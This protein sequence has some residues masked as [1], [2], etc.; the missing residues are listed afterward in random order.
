MSKKLKSIK[1]NPENMNITLEQAVIIANN[2]K[3]LKDSYFLEQLKNNMSYGYI[4]FTKFG[5]K[6][7]IFHEVTAIDEDTGEELYIERKAW[8]IK[9]LEGEWGATEFK[10]DEVTGEK[11]EIADVDGVFVA[12]GD[13]S[14]LVFCDDGEYLYL[15]EDLKKYVFDK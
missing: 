9:V 3:C 10:E 2:N 12:D 6:R 1:I 7:V 14:C 5:G 4:G 11:I 8:Y 15:T 13:I